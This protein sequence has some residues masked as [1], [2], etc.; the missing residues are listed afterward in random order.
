MCYLLNA[1][2][3]TFTVMIEAFASGLTMIISELHNSLH[4]PLNIRSVALDGR[5]VYP[6]FM[7]LMMYSAD[8]HTLFSILMRYDCRQTTQITR[9]WVLNERGSPHAFYEGQNVLSSN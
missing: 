9:Q 3:G 8:H 4:R 6:W 1:V 5:Q 7:I 2:M